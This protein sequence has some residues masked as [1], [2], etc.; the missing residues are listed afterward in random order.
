[1]VKV[2]LHTLVMA[3][4]FIGSEEGPSTGPSTRPS[5]G[6]SIGP[7]MRP[8][9]RRSGVFSKL[10]R[11]RKRRLHPLGEYIITLYTNGHTP[12]AVGLRA[13]NSHTGKHREDDFMPPETFKGF[14][15]AFG[16]QIPS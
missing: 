15:S 8:L 14:P 7:S 1:M 4:L 16:M 13:V 9:R 11:G 5:T 12:K 6:P 10:N 2:S 3:F